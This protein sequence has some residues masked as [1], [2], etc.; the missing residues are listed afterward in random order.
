MEF[1]EIIYEKPWVVEGA[2]RITINRPPMNTVTTTTWRELSEAFED[3]ASDDSIGVIVLTGA[4]EKAFCIG[5]GFEPG[6]KGFP[7]EMK[8]YCEKTHSIIRDAPKPVIA[9]V[10]GLA[11]GGGHVLHVL[12]DLT[13]ASEKARFGQ[14][15]PKVGSF[16]AGFGSAYLAKVVGEKKA[17]EIWYLCKLYSAEDAISMGLVNKIVPPDKLEEETLDWCKEILAKS[18][19]ALRFL[20][21]SFNQFSDSLRGVERIALDAVWQ[22]YDTEEAQEGV[23]A[24]LEK[25]T[26]DWSKWRGGSKN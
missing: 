24:F 1:K 16:D 26:P 23:S 5:G 17:R 13:I 10:N 25:R 3:A 9:S 8:Q 21:A 7:L 19:T 11:I 18:P 4:G 14:A 15:G 6:Q 12:C 20:K 2:A 22:F